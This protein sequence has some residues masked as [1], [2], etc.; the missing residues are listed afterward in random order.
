MCGDLARCE[1]CDASVAQ[2]DSTLECRR[3]STTRPIV[4]AS[5]GATKFKNVR[6][7]VTRVREELEALANTAVVEV[8]GESADSTLPDSLVYVGTEAVL[9]QV[10]DAQIVAFLDFDQELLAPRYRA[11]EQALS[12]L[13]LAA[14]LVGGRRG[15][16]RVLVQTRIPQ[17]EVIQ[18]VLHADPERASVAERERRAGLRFPPVSAMAAISGVSAGTFI[19]AFG[20]PLGVEVLGPSDG[21]WLLGSGD[22]QTLC[23][24]LAATARPSG[25]LRIEVDPLRI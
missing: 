12:L 9:H 14:R 18:A 13:V 15:G 20:S 25:R 16:G 21:M 24:A 8:T 7:G 4:C 17:H 23:D 6:A 1:K 19:E 2:V 10:R 3:C 11:A 5:C 22:H